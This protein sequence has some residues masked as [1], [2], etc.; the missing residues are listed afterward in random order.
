MGLHTK[1]MVRS[2]HWILYPTPISHTFCMGIA[3]T[4]RV[5]I[6]NTWASDLS[7]ILYGDF[8][9]THFVWGFLSYILYGDFSHTFCMGIASTLG[10]RK[11]RF[12]L[13]WFSRRLGTMLCLPKKNLKFPENF[14]KFLEI[15][16]IRHFS[17]SPHHITSH[18]IILKYDMIWYSH[19]TSHHITSGFFHF[20]TLH[21]GTPG[22]VQQ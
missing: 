18:M 19:I 15:S 20:F 11:G 17:F 21:Q 12:Q 6:R 2:S 4:L 22:T 5:P 10:A 14:L 7:Y 8:S 13:R 1:C 16:E 3:S 9:H